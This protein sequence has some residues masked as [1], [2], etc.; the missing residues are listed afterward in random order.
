MHIQSNDPN[1]AD[2]Q[3]QLSGTG[4]EFP[5]VFVDFNA[6]GTGDGSSWINAMTEIQ[7]AI[8]NAYQLGGLDVW[9]AKGV[10]SEKITLNKNVALYGGFIGTESIRDERDYSL[11]ETIIDG[12]GSGNVVI[13]PYLNPTAVIDGF[14]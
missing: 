1:N 14:T 4:R 6:T 13:A 2:Y 9:V 3:V 5:L 7:P 11:N 12:G 8:D 10:Y